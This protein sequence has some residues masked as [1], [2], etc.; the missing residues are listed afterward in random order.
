MKYAV[1]MGS[2]VM[3]NTPSFVKIGSVIQN[4]IRGI[5]RHRIEI[6]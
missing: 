4:L 2:G 6:A 1:E 3:I 5:H